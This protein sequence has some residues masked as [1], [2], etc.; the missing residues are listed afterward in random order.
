MRLLKSM[1]PVM[2]AVSVLCAQSGASQRSEWNKPFKPFRIIGNVYYV[3]AAG[4]SSFLIVTPAGDILLDGGLAETAPQIEQHI[5]SLG[6]HMRDVKYLLNSHAHYDHCGGLAALKRASGAQMI[7]S[8]ADA[9]TLSSG[10]QL[11]YGPGQ[12]DTHF[13]AVKVDRLIAD[14]GTVSL[15]GVTLTAHLTPGHTKGATTWTMPVVE[16]GKT[17]QVVFDCSTTVAG[18]R[19]V[20][21]AKYLNIVADY[22]HSFAVLRSLPCDVFLAAHPFMFHMA[23]KVKEKN[24]GG[25]NPFIDPGELKAFVDQSEKDFREEL[26]KQQARAHVARV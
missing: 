3:G 19:L 1:C 2:L 8:K 24:A 17:Y 20:N 11:S 25:P 15:G 23:E 10:H 14:G 21:N 16:N 13:P 7:A 22:E 18:N 26:A 5:R 12:S 6:F 9:A 4:V